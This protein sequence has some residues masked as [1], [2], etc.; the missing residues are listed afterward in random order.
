MKKFKK[1]ILMLAILAI[2]ILATYSMT[3]YNLKIEN[4]QR[5]ETGELITIN[6]QD[7]YYE[8]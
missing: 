1:I 7:Y 5:T 3:I 6:G 8:F 4:V 2:T